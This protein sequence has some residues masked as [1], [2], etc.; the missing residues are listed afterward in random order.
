VVDRRKSLLAGRLCALLASVLIGSAAVSAVPPAAEAQGFDADVGLDPGHSYVDVGAAG[1][2]LRE[3][4]LTLDIALRV[5]EKLE[6][7]GL[8]VRMSRTDSNPLS[9]MNHRDSTERTR[10]EQEARVSSVG[11]VRAYISL[12]FN[13]SNSP[14]LRGTETYYNPDGARPDDSFRLANALQRGVVDALW[15]GGYQTVDRGVKSD[16]LAGKPYGHFFGLRG[17]APSALVEGLF[18][19]SPGEAA[20]LNATEVREALSWG[21]VRGILE[22]FAVSAATDPATRS[23]QQTPIASTTIIPDILD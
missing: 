17:P 13:G 9:P 11:R 8:S 21:Y 15:E 19:S 5:R 18:L 2:G 6:Q 4:E 3:F 16:L 10:I 20:A 1:G 14:A 22:F 23:F 7:R 12:H